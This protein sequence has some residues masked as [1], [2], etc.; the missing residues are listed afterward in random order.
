MKIKIILVDDDLTSR[1]TIKTLLLGSQVYE[2]VCDFSDPKEALNWLAEND[3][4]IVFTDMSMPQMNGIE[5]IRM[6]RSIRQDLVF[7]AISGYDDYNYLRECM[8]NSVSD[9][10]L[11][12]QLSKEILINVLDS[13]CQRYGLKTNKAEENKENSNQWARALFDQENP[14]FEKIRKN[15]RNGIINIDTTELVVVIINPD[16]TLKV[17]KTEIN[18]QKNYPSHITMILSD[19]CNQIISTKYKH[20]IYITGEDNVVVLFS[21]ADIASIQYILSTISILINRIRNMAKRLLG[22]TLTV[23]I[24]GICKSF[25]EL[26]NQYHKLLQLMEEKLYLGGNRIFHHDEMVPDRSSSYFLCPELLQSIEY[27]VCS[28]DYELV[29][30]KIDTIFHDIRK[31]H[32][33]RMNIEITCEK[34]TENMQDILEKNGI[35]DTHTL[36]IPIRHFEFLEQYKKYALT[37]CLNTSEQ[38]REHIRTRFSPPV[39]QAI[40]YINQHLGENISLEDCAEYVGISYTHMSRLLKKETGMGFAECLNKA[41]INKAKSLISEGDIFIKDVV[42]KSGFHNYNYFFKVF[43]DIEGVTPSEYIKRAKHQIKT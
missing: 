27:A 1:N 11:K 43:R 15:I 8:R 6:A 31:A 21:F 3:T 22:L 38:I 4:Q 33:D 30:A 29:K 26:F 34:L 35:K 18:F 24:S 25:E 16:Y 23:G 19:I 7:I 12:H 13:T 2:V 9:Y 14:N 32:C 36:L 5:F 39:F 10:L 17:D 20:V 41:R 42:E 40:N 28:Q 37:V